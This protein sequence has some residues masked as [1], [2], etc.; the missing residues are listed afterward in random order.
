MKALVA[1]LPMDSALRREMG[2]DW[3]MAHELC[4]LNVEVAF[5]VYRA[6]LASGGVKRSRLP[7][8]LHI[9]RPAELGRK[10]P[11]PPRER[12]RAS[13]VEEVIAVLNAGHGGGNRWHAPQPPT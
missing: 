9:P 5:E 11:A 4:A 12:R 7:K 6:V 1:Y 8:S 2:L 3:S 10:R 13:T